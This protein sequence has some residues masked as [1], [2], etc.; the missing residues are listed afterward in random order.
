MKKTVLFLF[1]AVFLQSCTSYQ[2]ITASK[3]EQIIEVQGSKNEIYVKANEWMVRAFNNAESV[4]QFQD[5]EAGKIIGK[6]LMHSYTNRY[7]NYKV[8][9]IIT[10]TVRDGATKIDI[11]PIDS[12]QYDSSG[13]TI[14][15]YSKEDA[16]ADI[17][18]LTEDYIAYMTTKSESW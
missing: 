16:E 3:S 15:N 1:V 18:A 14:Y 11:E 9:S 8:Y 4:I 13:L 6:Y 12:W 10:I 5:K 17:A 7:V 2:Q